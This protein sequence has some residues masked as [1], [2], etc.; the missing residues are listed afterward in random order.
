KNDTFKTLGKSSPNL[1]LGLKLTYRVMGI[2]RRVFPLR[3][4]IYGSAVK[5]TADCS[6][7]TDINNPPDFIFQRS[8]YY[9]P[10]TLNIYLVHLG[11]FLFAERNNRS[12]MYNS[13]YSLHSIRQGYGV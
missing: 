13:C 9:V 5:L 11:S 1:Q 10:G 12:A 6:N 3:F 7:R 4:F 8:I 2:R